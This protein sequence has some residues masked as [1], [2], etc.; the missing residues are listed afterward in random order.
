MI[1]YF[2]PIRNRTQ[3]TVEYTAAIDDAYSIIYDSNVHLEKH[4]LQYLR[5]FRHLF[6]FPDAIP[7]KYV[8]GT[9]DNSANLEAVGN[10]IVYR[11][12][13]SSNGDYVKFVQDGDDLRAAYGLHAVK[14]HMFERETWIPTNREKFLRKW[15][16]GRYLNCLGLNISNSS[17]KPVI[18]DH[19][20]NNVAKFRDFL[21]SYSAVPFLFGGTL[22]GWYRECSFIK[23]TTD[24]D[25]AMK[26]TSLD[27]RM[28]KNMEKL[29]DL[30]LFWIL[31]KI[32]DSLEVSV[33]SANI[34]IDLFFMY[35]TKNFAW[36][37]GMMISEK[38]KFR[39]VY[40]LISQICTGDLLGRLFHVPCNI[41]EVLEADY[42]NWRIPHPTANFTWYKSHKNVHEA[43]YWNESEW[44]DAYKWPNAC[45]EVIKLDSSHRFTKGFPIKTDGIRGHCQAPHAECS[46]SILE[47][48]FCTAS[49]ASREPIRLTARGGRNIDIQ[50]MLRRAEMEKVS[51]DKAY[52]AIWVNGEE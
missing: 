41:E 35:E 28:L 50:E 45:H 27:P 21:D 5:Q 18:P 2:L 33:Y 52:N 42:G 51:E 16:N 29:N 31:G 23:D 3:N 15:K 8:F 14:R 36:V 47:V 37:G 4:E 34:K 9:Y 46:N 24:V 19:Y 48:K 17:D 1:Y 43:G 40:P 39:W 10:I 26:I 12:I 22:L 25:L 7:Q 20:V 49:L 6:W 13:N 44:D 38:K 11:M 30:K 32:N